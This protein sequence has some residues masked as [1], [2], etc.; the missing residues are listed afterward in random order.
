[1]AEIDA[2]KHSLAEAEAR[3]TALEHKIADLESEIAQLKEQI[4]E[5]QSLIVRSASFEVLVA[6][7]PIYRLN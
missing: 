7:Q 5:L 3:I 2:L 6:D 1:M 4:A